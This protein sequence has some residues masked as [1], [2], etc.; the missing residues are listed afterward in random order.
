[1]SKPQLLMTGRLLDTLSIPVDDHFTVLR[2]YDMPRAEADAA[3]GAIASQISAI[4]HSSPSRQI[5]GNLLDRLPN[6]KIV[7]NFGVGY[8]SIDA[9]A[10]AERGVVVT[11]TPD[12]LTE[13]VADTTLGLLLMTVRELSKAETWLRDGKWH[14]VGDYPLTPLSLRGR[15]VG[16][17][18]L[19][20]IGRA[21][22]TRCAAFGLPISYFG[23]TKKDDAPYP[24]YSDLVA[25]AHDVDTLIIV[26]PGTAETRNLINADVLSALGGRGVVVNVARGSVVD[27]TALIEALQSRTIA[28]AGLDVMWNEPNIDPTLMTLDNC[29]LLPHVGSASEATRRAMGQLVLDNLLAF[30]N[31]TPPPTP[32]PETPFHAWS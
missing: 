4:A 9:R 26:T 1:M 30:K 19:G 3:I 20:R 8:D 5:D 15:S 17:V 12:V 6:V 21:I 25:M 22:A 16:I 18:G 32:V 2:T 31:A 7:A 23:R 27:E 11:N 10:A 24:F 14:T 29:V 28:A 13:E